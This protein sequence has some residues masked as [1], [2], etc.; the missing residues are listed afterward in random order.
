[1]ANKLTPGSNLKWES[2]RMILPEQREMWLEHQEKQRRV[3]KPVLDEQQWEE[4]E[5]LLA[6]AMKENAE[7]VFTYWADDAVGWCHYVNTD[8]KQFHVKDNE[9]DVHFISFDLIT[10]IQY[11]I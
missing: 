9:K 6:E 5:W 10:N 11:C 3:K 8:Q 7:L 4:F 1:M 2:M